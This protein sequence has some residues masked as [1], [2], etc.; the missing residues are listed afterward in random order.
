MKVLFIV[1]EEGEPGLKAGFTASKRNF[2]KA[3]DRNCIK[4]VM[5]EAYRL[6]KLP[7][8]QRL[9]D[10]G[11]SVSIFLIYINKELPVSAEVHEK[12]GLIL[13]RLTD[14]ILPATT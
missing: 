2:K 3:V 5:R 7:L 4:R 11:K 6:Q 10:E 9:V 13:Q 1:N 14:K 8:Q 12:I